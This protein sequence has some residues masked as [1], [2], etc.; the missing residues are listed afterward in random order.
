MDVTDDE[1]VAVAIPIQQI[2]SLSLKRK[3]PA[4]SRR[5]PANNLRKNQPPPPNYPRPQDHVK[6]SV[7][8]TVRN[9]DGRMF[10]TTEGV[11]MASSRH[12]PVEFPGSHTT[13]ANT[14]PS[15][16]RFAIPMQDV[17]LLAN[18]SV[19]YFPDSN[20]FDTT[21]FTNAVAVNRNFSVGVRVLSDLGSTQRPHSTRQRVRPPVSSIVTAASVEIPVRSTVCFHEQGI[22]LSPVQK[23]RRAVSSQKI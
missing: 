21:C 7:R 5:L 23:Q 8:T 13:R 10:A 12:H 11:R 18:A 20:G 9:V 16:G 19:C 15:G 14:R 3:P 1:Y 4:P 22:S 6:G 17:T 2:R